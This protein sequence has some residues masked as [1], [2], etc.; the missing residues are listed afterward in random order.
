LKDAIRVKTEPELDA[1]TAHALSLYHI[2]VG[3]LDMQKQLLKW[4]VYSRI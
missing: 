4:R 3:A 2:N 1:I